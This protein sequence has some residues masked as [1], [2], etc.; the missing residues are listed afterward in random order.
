MGTAIGIHFGYHERGGTQAVT[1]GLEDDSARAGGG[2]RPEQEYGGAGRAGRDTDTKDNRIRREIP[3]PHAKTK[4]RREETM[5]GLGRIYQRNSVWWIGYY[6]RGKE[7]RETT[8]SK[9]HDDAVRLLKKRLGQMGRGRL[10][11]NEERITFVDMADA[12][13]KDYETKKRK[14]K[15]LRSARMAVKHLKTKFKLHRAVDIDTTQITDYVSERQAAGAANATINRE[16][17][18]LKRMFS[19]QI[20]A[21]KLVS[22]PYI[23]MLEENNARQG[24]LDHGDFLKLRDKLPDYLKDPVMFLY[25]SGWRVSEMRSLEWR[26]VFMSDRVVRLR[27]EV[28]KNKK[29]R[30]LPLRGELW[31]IFKRAEGNRRLDCVYVFHLDGAPIG[32][33]RKSWRNARSEAKLGHVL[34]HDLRRTCVRNLVKSGVHEKVAMGISGHK[35]RSVFDR[36]NIVNTEDL[37]E[38]LDKSEARLATIGTDSKVVGISQS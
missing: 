36:Y 38:A 14:P 25:K 32:D 28:A 2:A 21:N 37:A 7:Q 31:E 27:P 17:S 9:N 30:E 35:T 26:D 13:T 12:F 29:G 19:I 34:V 3:S 24:F 20:K 8:H 22:K 15:S 18:A 11:V 23:E 33:F 1:E 5:A 16:L 4:K 6:F 10:T